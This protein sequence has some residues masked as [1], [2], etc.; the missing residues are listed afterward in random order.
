MPRTDTRLSPLEFVRTLGSLYG[1]A[2][3]A[4][5]ALD[6]T[7]QRFRRLLRRAYGVSM[8]APSDDVAAAVRDARRAAD[9]TPLL[10]TLRACDAAREDLSLHPNRALALAQELDDLTRAFHLAGRVP[11][12]K[13]SANGGGAA[14]SRGTSASRDG[15][16]DRRP[17]RSQERLPRR[18]FC[19]KATRC[20]KACPGIAKTLTVKALV[21]AARPRVPARA[22]HVRPDARRHPRHERRQ[23]VAPARFQLHK[24]P[25]FTDLLLVDEINRMPPRTQAALLECMEERQ[26]TIDGM[27]HR[28]VRR[29]S[30]CSRRRTRSSSKARIRCRRRSSIAS[31]LKIRVPYPDA[32]DE[33]ALLT[34]VQRGFDAHNLDAL[35]IDADRPEGLLSQARARGPARHRAG[36]ALR[37]HRRRSCAATR[38]WPALVARR[39][40]AR[41][42]EPDARRQS[43]SPPSTAATICSP[44]T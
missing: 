31:S 16:G 14:R 18:R 40:P 21:A 20:S 44:T 1:R 10:T 32:E 17:G 29:S 33:I 42:G 8:R 37:L 11:A 30:P 39:E 2:G 27:R 26:V 24:G 13:E 28:A 7:Y 12:P 41:R 36:R 5:T 25:A 15:Q 23:P 35:G 3:A 34:S 43:A 6:A 4:S 9:T 19:A 38:D 22:V